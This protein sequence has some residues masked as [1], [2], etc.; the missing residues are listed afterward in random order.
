MSF[1]QVIMYLKPWQQWVNDHGKQPWWHRM[2]HKHRAPEHMIDNASMLEKIYKLIMERWKCYDWKWRGSQNY[3]CWRNKYWFNL[4][5]LSLP[6]HHMKLIFL[7]DF[8]RCKKNVAS[9]VRA[10]TSSNHSSF[11]VQGVN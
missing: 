6:G 3:S 7:L 9:T 5:T 8:S 2:D 11:L 4:Y 10:S 1:N